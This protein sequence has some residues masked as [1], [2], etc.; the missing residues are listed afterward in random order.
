MVVPLEITTRQHVGSAEFVWNDLT[1]AAE[2]LFRDSDATFGANTIKSE[3]E[4]YY[5]SASYGFIEWFTLGA[6]YA[7]YYPDKDDKDGDK[8]A[9]QEKPDHRAWQKDLAVTFRFNLNEY[10]IVK[11]EGHAVDGSADVL[12]IDNPAPDNDF[13]ESNWYYGAAKVTFSF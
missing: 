4:S 1:V 9:A 2:Y 3:T 13:S 11:V 12:S 10:W 6:Y 5:L 7:I 8:L